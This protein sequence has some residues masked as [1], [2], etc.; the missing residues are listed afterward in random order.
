MAEGII[1]VSGN[2]MYNDI[3]ILIQGRLDATS[4]DKLPYYADIGKVVLSHD[5]HNDIDLLSEYNAHRYCETIVSNRIINADTIANKGYIVKNYANLGRPS[6][7]FYSIYS[8][9]HGLLNCRT[10]YTIKLRSDEFVE[11]LEPMISRFLE[12]TSKVV[13]SNIFYKDCNDYRLHFGDH[14]FIGRT[15]KLYKAYQT[16]Y[17]YY[18]YDI[19]DSR[20]DMDEREKNE[21]EIILTK[22]ILLAY[23]M[24]ITDENY[25]NLIKVVDINDMKPYLVRYCGMGLKWQDDYD[26]R[27]SS[28]HHDDCQ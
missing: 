5:N 16:I 12:D 18:V 11:N 19:L 20:L 10:K 3:S 13:C 15:N 17:N 24:G 22:S 2:S 6:T 25:R 14:M 26:Y 1:I 28:K 8:T 27:Y 7:F 4:L 21:A 9:Y 23:G